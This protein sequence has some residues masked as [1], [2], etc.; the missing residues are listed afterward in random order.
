[1]YDRP[2]TAAANDRLW[3]G[4]R[5]RL[6]YGPERLTREGDP[7]DHW[8]DPELL[9]SQT[10]GLPYRSWLHDKVSLVGTPVCD[11]ADC[12][13]G[14]YYS[15]IIARHDDP[16]GDPADFADAVLAYNEALSQSGWAAPQGWAAARGFAFDRTRRTGSHANSAQA[17]ADGRADIAAL[18]ALSWRLMART[19]GV[20][21]RL[22]VIGRT[23]AAPALPWITAATRDPAPIRAALSGALA[24]LP[25]EDRDTLGI[26]GLVEIPAAAYRALPLPA[27]PASEPA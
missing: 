23:E 2:E 19:D 18:D 20:G 3:Q 27:P 8:K 1:M 17:V 24:A 5:T 26:T 6:G 14:H 21:A 12:P 22:R 11:L 4:V 15:V 16:R 7:R 25:P 10:C 9:L 13:P